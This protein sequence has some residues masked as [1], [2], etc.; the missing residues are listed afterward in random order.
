MLLPMDDQPS[1]IHKKNISRIRE[2]LKIATL[3]PRT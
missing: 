2:D 3:M 1:D